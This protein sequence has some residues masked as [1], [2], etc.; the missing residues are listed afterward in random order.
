MRGGSFL[1]LAPSKVGVIPQSRIGVD[2]REAG[3]SLLI[4]KANLF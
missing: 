1:V 2:I 4:N 3:S